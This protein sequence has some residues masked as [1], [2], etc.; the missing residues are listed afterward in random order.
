MRAAIYNFEGKITRVWKGASNRFFY[1]TFCRIAIQVASPFARTCQVI[2]A[3][4]DLSR[5]DARG[6]TGR[7]IGFTTVMI[8][9]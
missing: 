6:G 1:G 7:L 5:I 3:N 2:R 9:A 4:E 8:L